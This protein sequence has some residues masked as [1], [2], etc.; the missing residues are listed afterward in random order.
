VTCVQIDQS[1]SV[2]TT[3]DLGQTFYTITRCGR[4][5]AG[6]ANLDGQ[7]RHTHRP[8]RDDPPIPA[9]VFAAIHHEGDLRGLLYN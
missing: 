2:I 9:A 1:W 5:V 4:Q 6:V 8:R 3:V 7:W